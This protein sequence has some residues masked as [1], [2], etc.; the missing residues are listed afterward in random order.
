MNA[1]RIRVGIGA[2]TEQHRVFRALADATRRS[3]LDLLRE[4]PRTTG[5]LCSRFT[6]MSRFAVMKHLKLLEQSKLVV[7]RREGKFR[8]NYLNADPIR[9]IDEAWLRHYRGRKS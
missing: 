2:V 5:E 4:K 3:V 7:S 9:R 1:G 8:W 6:Q